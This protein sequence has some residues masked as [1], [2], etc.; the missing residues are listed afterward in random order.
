[1]IGYDLISKFHVGLKSLLH[2]EPPEFYG[3]LV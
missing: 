3:N 2:Q 1:M